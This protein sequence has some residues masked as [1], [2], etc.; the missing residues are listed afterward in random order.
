MSALIGHAVYGKRVLDKYFPGVDEPKFFVGTTFPDIRNIGVTTRDRTHTHNIRL[1]DLQACENVFDLGFKLHSLVDDIHLR[2]MKDNGVYNF[3]SDLRFAIQALKVFEDRLLY[4]KLKNWTEIAGYFDD[5]F[6]EEKAFK[7]DLY[8]IRR[9]HNF[10][11]RYYFEGPTDNSARNFNAE[12]GFPTTR[13]DDFL[14]TLQYLE[15]KKEI[16][17]AILKFYD[18]FDQL[19]A[20]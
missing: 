4:P 13:A 9:W 2:F 11:K 5:I 14:K 17:D 20:G 7:I 18:Q 12:T 10:I 6:D 3:S 1:I 19:I 8:D 15:G 16:E